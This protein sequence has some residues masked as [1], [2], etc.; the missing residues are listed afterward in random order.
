MK[1]T[2]SVSGCTNTAILFLIIKL[3]VTTV[4]TAS[5]KGQLFLKIT[6]NSSSMQSAQENQQWMMIL[7]LTVILS[8]VCYQGVCAGRGPVRVTRSVVESLRDH[9]TYIISF[10]HHVTEEEL[11]RFSAALSKSADEDE[12]FT[13]EII[14]ELFV[15][16][17]LTAKLSR[18]A[19]S[20]VRTV[21]LIFLK[22]SVHS[23][24]N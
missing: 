23:F 10:K 14:E 9:G 12:I 24:S 5:L 17:C 3:A 6:V 11:L 18:R 13:T 16:K 15:I 7:F 19:L 22:L 1:L 20:W 4:S 8:T 21:C 2:V